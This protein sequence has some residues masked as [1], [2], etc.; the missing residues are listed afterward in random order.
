MMETNWGAHACCWVVF[1]GGRGKEGRNEGTCA[2]SRPLGKQQ[3][4]LCQEK[5]ESGGEDF[6]IS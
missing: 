4:V 6:W 3:V 5:K 2:V 1:S